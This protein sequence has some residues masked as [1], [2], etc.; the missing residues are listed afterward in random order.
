M[1][2][3]LRVVM[4]D[5]TFFF[6]CFLCKNHQHKA[7]AWETQ[8][9]WLTSH[10]AGISSHQSS[11]RYQRQNKVG[12]CVRHRMFL[13]SKPI[14][15]HFDIICIPSRS[16]F[17]HHLFAA[18]SSPV[19][20]YPYL[21]IT[22]F[23][24]LSFPLFS[25]HSYSGPDLDCFLGNVFVFL[26]QFQSALENGASLFF[27]D[28]CHCS[29]G[30]VLFRCNWASFDEPL[31]AWALSLLHSLIFTL[32]ISAKRQR[33]QKKAHL[34]PDT[35]VPSLLSAL[36][37]NLIIFCLQLFL[38]TSFFPE[39]QGLTVSSLCV[40]IAVLCVDKWY[41]VYLFG[42]HSHLQD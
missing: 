3:P 10:R 8:K 35:E 5:I 2:N 33:E 21:F 30:T 7:R 18:R 32:P 17:L 9:V 40:P 38:C 1:R 28:W 12:R 39:S 24:D 31:G 27:S 15:H 13:V 11:A 16:I 34:F 26:E 29:A 6:K 4:N 22:L 25:C 37:Y 14:S 23:L 41:C 36:F 19:S 42:V 20:L